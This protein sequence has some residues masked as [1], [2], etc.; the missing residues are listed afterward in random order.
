MPE[1]KL[2]AFS[3]LTIQLLTGSKIG[4]DFLKGFEN[5]YYIPKND[6]LAQ[7]WDILSL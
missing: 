7:K 3:F 5:R 2:E 6:I 4:F 1:G